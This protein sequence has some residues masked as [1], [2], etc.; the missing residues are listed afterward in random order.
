M[1]D[2]LLF[3][4]Q[5]NYIILALS[6]LLFFLFFFF[7][8]FLKRHLQ[9]MKVARL[10]VESEL[11]LLAYTTATATWDPSHICDLC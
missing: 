8:S 11:Q 7:L 5:L 6:I 4:W 2:V 9:H 1:E 3:V 10:G